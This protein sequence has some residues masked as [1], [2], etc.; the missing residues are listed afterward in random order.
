MRELGPADDVKAPQARGKT[1]WEPNE[2]QRKQENL[3]FRSGAAQ[4]GSTTQR[5]Q[6]R[7]DGNGADEH[8]PS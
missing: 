4:G 8:P 6:G 3:G 5:K 2:D 1:L 7:F